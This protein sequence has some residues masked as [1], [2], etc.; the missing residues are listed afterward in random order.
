MRVIDDDPVIQYLAAM[1]LAHRGT[2]R[3]ILSLF[4]VVT[5]AI[6]RLISG[7][8]IV[9]RL[10]LLR[11]CWID[12]SHHDAGE[13]QAVFCNIRYFN[14]LAGRDDSLRPMIAHGGPQLVGPRLLHWDGQKV[15]ES[16]LQHALV[17]RAPD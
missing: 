14:K 4:A 17:A 1:K 3:G 16:V 7:R 8:R 12:A 9:R 15:N 2:V 11:R 13:S 6:R 10:R 5:L